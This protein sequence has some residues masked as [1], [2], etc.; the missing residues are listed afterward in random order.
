MAPTDVKR[1]VHLRKLKVAVTETN[2]RHFVQAG[3]ND[4]QA[5]RKRRKLISLQGNKIPKVLQFYTGHLK[6]VCVQR[7]KRDALGADVAAV[8]SK[9]RAS[10]CP[11]LKQ[12]QHF[13]HVL[14]Q[15]SAELRRLYNHRGE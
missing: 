13:A 10:H 9:L 11:K 3:V 5:G 4:G 8:L 7:R 2:L 14:L 12:L 1:R 6:N 15:R